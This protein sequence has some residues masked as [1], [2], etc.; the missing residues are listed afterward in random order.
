MSTRRAHPATA[1]DG[2]RV[3]LRLRGELDIAAAPAVEH[4]FRALL[5]SG[6][7]V[8]A[9]SLGEVGFVDAAGLR[10]LEWCRRAGQRVGVRVLLDSPSA[11]VR[12]LLELTGT[13]DDWDIVPASSGPVACGGRSPSPR[14]RAAACRYAGGDRDLFGAAP[15]RPHRCHD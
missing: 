8:L 1:R 6:P 13:L 14:L 2:Y 9:L 5:G 7:P 3:D 4:Q 11:P 12:R 10:S 15:P